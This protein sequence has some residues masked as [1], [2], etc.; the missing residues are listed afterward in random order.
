[1]VDLGRV[2]DECPI[3]SK[4][5]NFIKS[6][7]TRGFIFFHELDLSFGLDEKTFTI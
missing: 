7:A 5:Q 6:R 2:V 3:N 1:M 4:C